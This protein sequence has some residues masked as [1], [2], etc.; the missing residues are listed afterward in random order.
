MGLQMTWS[1]STC[2]QLQHTNVCRQLSNLLLSSTAM[3]SGVLGRNNGA[4]VLLL[5]C[6]L[7]MLWSRVLAP[8]SIPH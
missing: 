1:Q 8:S 3:L 4:A 2:Q 5:W 7:C 6:V